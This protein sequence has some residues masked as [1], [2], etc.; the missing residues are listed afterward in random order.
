LLLLMV[1]MIM[2][3]E[4]VEL[5]SCAISNCICCGAGRGHRAHWRVA[6]ARVACGSKGLE[7]SAVSWYERRQ[8]NAHH[9]LDARGRVGELD[10]ER[11][12]YVL[13]QFAVEL[14]NGYFGFESF[15]KANK[16]NTL[17][18]TYLGE[19]KKKISL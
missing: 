4:G 2:M 5:V 17:G 6:I 8:R 7:E 18:F 9:R 1:M 19:F 3:N 11:L 16:A 15:V 10:H 14:F 13:V 12:G